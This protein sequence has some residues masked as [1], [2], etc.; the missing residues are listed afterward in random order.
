M[1]NIVSAFVLLVGSVSAIAAELPEPGQLDSR[2]RYI[3]YKYNDVTQI[4]V[5]R[6]TVTRIVLGDDEKILLAATGFSAECSK[7]EREWCI[8]ADKDTNQIWV[9]PKDGA[10]YNNLELKT[11]K[12]D[13]SMEFRVLPDS[14]KGKGEKQEPMFRVIYRYPLDVS[15]MKMMQAI[16]GPR[17]PI[18][19]EK[20]II[21]E[22]LAARPTPKNW[23]YSMEVLEGADNIAPSL[24]FDDGR[25]TYFEFPPNR[26]IPAIFYIAPTGAES[27]LPFHVENGLVVVQRTG[28]RFV[29]RLSEAVVGIWNDNPNPETVATKDGV[30]VDGLVR[31]LK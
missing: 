8:R 21:K 20:E 18:I 29:L 4:N 31:D 27:R 2:V 25:F 24:V 12:R 7:E 13:Y 17:E 26:E 9:K 15:P 16:G 28:Q 10:T 1:K 30:T 3:T 22:K 11:S 23:K 6:G 14:E 5:R 19:S